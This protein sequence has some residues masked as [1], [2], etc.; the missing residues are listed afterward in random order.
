MG[1][2][3]GRPTARLFSWF[4]QICVQH[5]GI[6]RLGHDAHLPVDLL[7]V[8]EE[9]DG[10]EEK[11]QESVDLEKLETLRKQIENRESVYKAAEQEY[12]VKQSLLLAAQEEYK[13]L[14]EKTAAIAKEM[15]EKK[16]SL[17]EELLAYG[18][19]S[20]KA[21]RERVR[22]LDQEREDWK[23]SE[24]AYIDSKQKLSRY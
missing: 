24:I 11:G 2:L 8:L 10:G 5:G 14:E 22:N 16:D 23:L 13:E 9:N 21:E 15:E 1:R 18:I 20:L 3:L 7:A 17:Q 12:Q 6:S 19:Q 4:L